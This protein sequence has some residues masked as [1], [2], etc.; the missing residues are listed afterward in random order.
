MK[1]K[2]LFILMALLL[3]WPSNIMAKTTYTGLRSPQDLYVNK[4]KT[5]LKGFNINDNNYYR[6]R[7]LAQVLKLHDYNFSLWGDNKRIIINLDESY[8][9]GQDKATIY[10]EDAKVSA[11][12]KEMTLKLIKN[13]KDQSYQITAYNIDG[14]NYFKLRDM[15]QY[16][17]Y[18]V[19]Y[20]E[21]ANAAIIYTNVITIKVPQAKKLVLGNERLVEEYSH[22]I[23][24]K[25]L[26]L[27]T[28]QTGIDSEGKRT[29]DKLYHY[30]PANLKAIYSPEHGLDGKHLAGEYVESYIDQELKLPV[31]SLYGKTRQPSPDMLKGI[32]VLI[33]D[34]QDIGS[35]T[36]TYIS[37]LNYAMK[38]AATAKI[39]LIVLDRPNPLG[40]QIVEGFVL[41]E[42][43]K[44]FVGVDKLPMAHGMTVGELA[45]FF[46]RNIGADLE[47]VEM[48]GYKRSM[49]WQDTDLPFSQTSPN[50][51]NLE[52]AFNYMATGIGDN[53]GLGQA[54]KFTWVGAKGLDSQEF[55][56]RLNAY[57]LPGLYFTAEDKG[58]RGGVRLTITDYHLYSPQKTGTYILATANLLDAIN[59][60]EEVDGKVPMFEKIH[61]GP[62][63]GQALKMKLSPE[64]IVGL[65]Q[66][67]LRDFMVIREK[68][69][70]YK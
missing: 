45:Q 69:L 1:K 70:L 32:D 37:T 8:D 67:E 25:S 48:K 29:V 68:Y 6:L 52:S 47:I 21:A 19:D 33:F 60:P 12:A 20:N 2:I 66:D 34:I 58:E 30:G 5:D 38:A 42:G 17:D 44:T 36:Y 3:V 23:D 50:I 18:Q 57:G 54:D 43:Y 14:Y 40:G 59:I 27:I 64:E 53:T 11:T 41:D 49:I 15:G 65:Y 16:L 9:P 10:K 63:M 26:G 22:L 55:A 51:P 39:P 28:N 24:G 13:G 61:G 35:R 62:M 4:Q 46:N 56:R 7:D 31:Y